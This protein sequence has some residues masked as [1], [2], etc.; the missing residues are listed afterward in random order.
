MRD[1]ASQEAASYPAF[2]TA[3]PT[4]EK[5]PRTTETFRRIDA[6]ASSLH[7][8]TAGVS[9]VMPADEGHWPTLFRI[10]KVPDLLSLQGK[11]LKNEPGGKQE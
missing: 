8:D 6:P 3:R 5:A 4:H 2:L 1:P 11:S 10:R 9:M 7:L